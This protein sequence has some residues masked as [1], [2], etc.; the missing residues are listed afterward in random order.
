MKR[1]TGIGVSAAL[2]LS[3][4]ALLFILV[5]QPLE[6]NTEQEELPKQEAIV[7]ELMSRAAVL[8]DM[9]TGELLFEKNGDISISPASL[10][11]L[12]TLHLAYRAI[13]RG[14]LSRDTEITVSERADF[15]KQPRGSSLMFLEEGQQ[16][17]VLE[18]MRGLAVPS[19]ND[20]AVALAEAVS[21]TLEDFV[22]EMNRE[23]ERLEL[24][25]VEFVEPAGIDSANR[26]TARSFGRFCRFYLKAHPYALEE[27]HGLEEYTYPNAWNLPEG[28]GSVYG[29]IT[30]ENYNL[31][32]GRHPWVDGLKTGYIRESGYNIAVT[33]THGE[34]RLLAVV[35][36]GPGEDTREG[37]LSRVIDGT[38]LISYGFYAYSRVRPAVPE[39]GKIK[40]WGGAIARLGIEMPVPEFFLVPAVKAGYLRS[41]VL[42]DG[43]LKAPVSEGQEVG[44]LIIF[45]GTEELGEYPVTAARS[46]EEGGVLRRV[47]DS[48]RLRFS[49]W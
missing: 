31:L 42:I 41:K 22:E 8:Y 7:P 48:L 30:Q 37:N 36:G 27:L 10:T 23:A 19:G 5:K 24:E 38:H 39:T 28:E 44:R 15:R 11:K 1:K 33:A 17:T 12:M 9:G 29:P 16:V 26:A 45:V 13:E 40:V 21:G 35:M 2:F 47:W 34:R 46:V 14:E 32:V 49:S 18:L 4:L 20:A 43:P 6:Q 25:E 3:I